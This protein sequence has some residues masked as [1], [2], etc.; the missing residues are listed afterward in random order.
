MKM[1][2]LEV[3]IRASWILMLCGLVGSCTPVRAPSMPPT[4]YTGPIAERPLQESGYSWV[5]VSVHGR[6]VTSSALFRNLGFPL[7][8]GKSWSYESTA[9]IEG[10][11]P[12]K[13]FRIP[14]EVVCDVLSFKQITVIA[15]TFGAFQCACQCIIVGDPD[16]SC[17]QWT[18]WYAPQVKNVI[19]IERESTENS[20]ELV[21]YGNE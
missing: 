9:I 13:A 17:D 12:R 11:N 18:L 2:R 19:S 10:A 21:E 16:T 7:W 3:L 15:G 1:A 4:N 20:F 8:I 5:Y 14:M 6:R